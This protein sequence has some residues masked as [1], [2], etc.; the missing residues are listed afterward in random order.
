MRCKIF[1]HKEI[2]TS[3]LDTMI[4][5]KLNFQRLMNELKEKTFLHKYYW[6]KNI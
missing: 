3:S 6:K 4:R 1:E 2:E 5:E